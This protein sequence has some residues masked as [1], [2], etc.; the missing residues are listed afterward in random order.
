VN[1][2]RAKTVGRNEALYREVNERIQ[3]VNKAFGTLAADDLA[4][5]CECGRLECHEQ[6]RVP[7]DVYARVRSDS[8]RFVV[9]AGHE[10]SDFEDVIDAGGEYV[11]VVKKPG[12]PTRIATDTDPRE[13]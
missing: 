6:I 8:T 12:T 4:A 9:K 10:M 11:V 1:D 3:D 7:A 13:N 2:E 5:F